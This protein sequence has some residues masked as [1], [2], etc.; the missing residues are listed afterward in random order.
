MVRRRELEELLKSAVDFIAQPTGGISSNA[1]LDHIPNMLIETESSSSGHES[2]VE[3]RK[4][5]HRSDHMKIHKTKMTENRIKR[6]R[7]KELDELLKDAVDF[8]DWPTSSTPRQALN[9]PFNIS[10]DQESSDDRTRDASGNS[11]PVTKTKDSEIQRRK[12]R[13]DRKKQEKLKVKHITK[14]IESIDTHVK[15]DPIK[16]ECKSKQIIVMKPKPINRPRFDL[17][18]VLGEAGSLK[19]AQTVSIVN[20]LQMPI[21]ELSKSEPSAS[22]TEYSDSESEDDVIEVSDGEKGQ[23]KF[24]SI[25]HNFVD[26]SPIYERKRFEHPLLVITGLRVGVQN[27]RSIERPHYRIGAPSAH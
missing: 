1:T 26:I 25:L 15:S 12:E 6:Q 17:L 8:M 24:P 22:E 16:D 10:D 5:A 23:F 13:K 7:P 21:I 4:K 27:S 14:Q 2:E 3:I 11:S 18:S 20:Q 9:F 19:P